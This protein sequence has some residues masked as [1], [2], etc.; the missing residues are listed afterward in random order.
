MLA[1]ACCNDSKALNDVANILKRHYKVSSRGGDAVCF[2]AIEPCTKQLLIGRWDVSGSSVAA[3][4]IATELHTLIADWS[5]CMEASKALLHRT[6]DT[7]QVA[8]WTDADR[9]AWWGERAASDTLIESLLSKLEDL[10]GPLKRIFSGIKGVHPH[11][12]TASKCS[13]VFNPDNGCD[14]IN[15]P[16][17]S[18]NINEMASK[19]EDDQLVDALNSL[20][21]TELR[22]QLKEKK[23]SVIGKKS[24]LISRIQE[25]NSKNRNRTFDVCMYEDPQDV[26]VRSVTR[27]A[28]SASS[29]GGLESQAVG[30]RVSKKTN[31]KTKTREEKGI[32]VGVEVE[33]EN[34]DTSRASLH[35]SDATAPGHTVLILDE[36]LQQIPWEVIPCLRGKTCSRMPSFAL[37]LHMLTRHHP[38]EATADSSDLHTSRNGDSPQTLGADLGPPC[39]RLPSS[40]LEE[41]SAVR[42]SNLQHTWYVLDPEGNLPATRAT[43][44]AFLQPYIDQY[45]WRGYIGEIPSEETAKYVSTHFCYYCYYLL[46]CSE[47]CDC[48]P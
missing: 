20:K 3:L 41:S 15:K 25:F 36:T 23:L 17:K 33:E 31:I 42:T 24:E 10:L 26:I 1:A 37:L 19:I 12:T 11:D 48:R 44:S 9:R 5:A 4:P 46:S 21:V 6:V 45:R 8:R 13:G 7:A 43:M 40:S 22:Q 29:C 38:S 18:S 16:C 35:G 28:P 47:G 39:R 27:P 30:S 14:N 34:A 2:A 32:N